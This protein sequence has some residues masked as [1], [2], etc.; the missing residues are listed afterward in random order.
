MT[1][2]H[3]CTCSLHQLHVITLSFDWFTGSSV[4]FL[5]GYNN[6][7]YFGLGFTTPN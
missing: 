2:L 7:Y 1:R 6:N 4:S 5:I 3:M